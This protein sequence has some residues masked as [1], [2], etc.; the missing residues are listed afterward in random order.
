MTL[1]VAQIHC[2]VYIIGGFTNM[3]LREVVVE[4][5]FG[6]ANINTYFN[7]RILVVPA[8]YWHRTLPNIQALNFGNR[9]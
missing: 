7:V 9:C 8:I 5:A 4:F 3:I 2:D 1:L 6:L